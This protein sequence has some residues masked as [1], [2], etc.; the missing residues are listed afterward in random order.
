MLRQR[1]GI[2]RQERDPEQST[3]FSFSRVL[4]PALMEYQ[5]WAIFLDGD[6]LARGDIAALWGLR[7]DEYAL[8]CVQHA[9]VANETVAFL[10]TVQTRYGR[11]NRSSLMLFNCNAGAALT[12][13]DVNSATGLARHRFAWLGDDSRIGALP[14]G[15]WNLLIAGQPAGCRPASEGGPALAH[16]TKSGPWFAGC[17]SGDGVLAAEWFASREAAFRLWD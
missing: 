9:H 8:L 2:F 15:R 14:R 4:V 16:G 11:K 3:E 10:G 1:K 12:A 7:N 17:R 5:D 13:D 6:R